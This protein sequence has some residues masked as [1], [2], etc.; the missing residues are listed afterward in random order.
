MRQWSTQSSI[1]HRPSWMPSK[2]KDGTSHKMNRSDLLFYLDL[3]NHL[4]CLPILQLVLNI[5][6][7]Q[8]WSRRNNTWIILH[9]MI[10]SLCAF[11]AHCFAGC[12]WTVPC[13]DWDSGRRNGEASSGSVNLWATKVRGGN[14]KTLDQFS[15][16]TTP[17]WW[18]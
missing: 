3:S 18:Y 15:L 8:K 6:H 14:M 10:S 12:S 13:F 7:L 4:L 1:V 11:A 17:I 5:N 2:L 16:N 9:N